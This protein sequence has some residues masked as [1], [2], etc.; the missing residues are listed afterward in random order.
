MIQR[1]GNVVI[2]IL[3]N[4]KQATIKPLRLETVEAGTLVYADEYNIYSRL[5]AWGFSH[6]TVNHGAGEYARDEE[7]DGFHEVHVNTR[8]GFGSLLRSW[9]RP[10]RGI[11]RENCRVIWRSLSACTTSGNAGKL[12]CI[13][14]CLC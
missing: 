7:G 10:H 9:L 8:E 6:K 3:A 1:A 11:S 5:E 14:Y 4:V 2:R 13:P 12:H